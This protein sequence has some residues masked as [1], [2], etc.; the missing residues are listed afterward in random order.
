[1]RHNYEQEFGDMWGLPP[2][3]NFLSFFPIT[4]DPV[5]VFNG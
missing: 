4:D 1:M 3:N 5:F 2:Q